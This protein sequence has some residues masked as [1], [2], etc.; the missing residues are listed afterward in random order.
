MTPGPINQSELKIHLSSYNKARGAMSASY[1]ALKQIIIDYIGITTP[2]K[3]GTCF[4][5]LES[6]S[7]IVADSSVKIE[8]KCSNGIDE[9]DISQRLLAATTIAIAFPC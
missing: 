3:V 2:P 9:R 7:P 4:D 5:S 1:S 8:N 6:T